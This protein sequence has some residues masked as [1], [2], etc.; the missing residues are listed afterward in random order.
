MFC[1]DA[2]GSSHWPR[3][4]KSYCGVRCGNAGSGPAQALE[5]DPAGRRGHVRQHRKRRR[6]PRSGPLQVVAAEMDRGLDPPQVGAGFHAPLVDERPPDVAEHREGV[7]GSITP[8]ERHHQLRRR[9]LARR[10]GRDQWSQEIDRLRG[11]A[12]RQMRLGEEL[13]ALEPQVVQTPP[14]VTDGPLIDPRVRRPPPQVPC[15]G[16]HPPRGFGRAVEQP[17]PV[18]EARLEL[19]RVQP[20]RAGLDHI[21]VVAGGDEPARAVTAIG[22]DHRP[23]SADRSVDHRRRRPRDLAAPH[24]RARRPTPD[25][26]DPATATP[27]RRRPGRGRTARPGHRRPARSRRARRTGDRGP[28]APAVGSCPE[29]CD[30][31]QP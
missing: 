9:A 6:L 3:M 23:Q 7:D 24:R 30:H 11:R 27:T 15:T 8:I 25:A 12:R 10:M 1:S 28:H 2:P 31:C 22:V 19:R 18:D 13:D 20:D 17:P 26:R 21:R 29:A 5:A 16:Q 4:R 14:F